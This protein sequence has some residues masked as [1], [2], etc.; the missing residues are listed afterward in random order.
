M[1]PSQRT[2]VRLREGVV[3]VEKQSSESFLAKRIMC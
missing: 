1:S 2:D 3:L